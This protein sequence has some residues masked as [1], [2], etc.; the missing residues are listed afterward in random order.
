MGWLRNAWN[1]GISPLVMVRFHL[2]ATVVFLLLIYPSMV[3]LQNSVPYLVA[4]SV[5]ANFAGHLSAWQSARVEIKQD[6][7]SNNT[8]DI[9]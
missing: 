1:N 9:S 7:V 6:E 2:V 3:L 8:P 4:I 5:W